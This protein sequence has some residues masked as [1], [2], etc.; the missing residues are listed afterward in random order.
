MSYL[1]ELWKIDTKHHCLFHEMQQLLK[2]AFLNQTQ[3]K[4]P[5]RAKNW[6]FQATLFATCVLTALHFYF[7]Q[8]ILP[9]IEQMQSDWREMFEIMGI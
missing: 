6:E 2:N 3:Q 1:L 5:E 9:P 8:N 7:E 4:F